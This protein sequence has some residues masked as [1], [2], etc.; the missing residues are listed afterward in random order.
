[1]GSIGVIMEFGFVII[2]IY[3]VAIIVLTTRYDRPKKNR[4]RLT[5]RGGDFEA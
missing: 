5:G 4:S 3:A 1:M 2:A